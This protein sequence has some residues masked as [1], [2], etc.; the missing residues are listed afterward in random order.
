MTR[1]IRTLL[2]GISLQEATFQRR[3]FPDCA[4]QA[5]ERLES[6][7]FTFLTGYLAALE[8]SGDAD[9]AACLDTV[10]PERRGF[11]YEGAAMALGLMDILLPWRRDRWRSFTEGHARHHEY[12]MQVGLGWAIARMHRNVPK[13]IENLDPLIRWLAVDGYGFH[14]CYF[15]W[16][17]VMGQQQVPR[18][19]TGYSRNA[20][21]QG[22]GRCLWF[23]NGCDPERVADVIGRFP[24][25]RRSDLWSGAGLASAYAGGVEPDAL[26]ELK[27]LSGTDYPALAQGVVFATETR[28]HAG[29]LAPH[30]ELACTIICGIPVEQASAIVANER[31]ALPYHA[32]IPAFEVWRKRIQAHFTDERA[33]AFR[34]TPGNASAAAF[35]DSRS[36][37]Q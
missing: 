32:P 16:E 11:A 4:P 2:F 21:D 14:E 35:N 13:A 17:R 34:A 12:M 23:V 36:S 18:A 9:L 29:N 26:A 27:R 8:A 6:I 10:E 7:G 5:R 31:R 33:E 28:V 22:L 20:F 3:R 1:R 37:L 15:K 25:E 30:T 19:I 24:R